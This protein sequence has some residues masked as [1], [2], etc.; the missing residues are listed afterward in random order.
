MV[1]LTFF[2][3]VGGVLNF[4]ENLVRIKD[5]LLSKV[6]THSLGFN[7]RGFSDILSEAHLCT[8]NALT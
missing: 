1:S 3:G 4:L 6:D 2:L 8:Y 7:F 5:F